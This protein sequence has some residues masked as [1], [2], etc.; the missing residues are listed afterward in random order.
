[1][2]EILQPPVS[3]ELPFL[4]NLHDQKLPHGGHEIGGIIG[5]HLT[6]KWTQEDH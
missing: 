3:W 4:S 1:M 2:T 6:G 5:K